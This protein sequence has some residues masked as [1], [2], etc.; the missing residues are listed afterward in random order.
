MLHSDK[1]MGYWKRGNI[2]LVLLVK[3]GIQL[4]KATIAWFHVEMGNTLCNQLGPFMKSKKTFSVLVRKEVYA[5]TNHQ[6]LNWGYY[7]WKWT[8]LG[9]SDREES[10]GQLLDRKELRCLAV[11]RNRKEIDEDVKASFNR[12]VLALLWLLVTLS[13]TVV[14][15]VYA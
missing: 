1:V 9:V 11:R 15:Y 2:H 7:Q 14:F 10:N 12:F 8:L 13:R 3:T 5:S 4:G 6:E